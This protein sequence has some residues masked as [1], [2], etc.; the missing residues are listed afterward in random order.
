MGPG[1]LHKLE[2]PGQPEPATVPI[3]SFPSLPVSPPHLA[4]ASQALLL[5]LPGMMSPI[6]PFL[7][8]TS[9]LL[10]SRWPCGKTRAFS[11]GF[12]IPPA[13]LFGI[14][15]CLRGQGGLGRK[16]LMTLL[17]R[18]PHKAGPCHLTFII[19]LCSPLH[20]HFAFLDP[21]GLS[22]RTS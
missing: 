20:P 1:T 22:L 17:R 11:V 16:L 18:H 14:L 10:Q 15:A 8:G 13:F 21:Q 12:L 9:F 2:V 7:P 3:C 5:S 6:L 4:K 19:V